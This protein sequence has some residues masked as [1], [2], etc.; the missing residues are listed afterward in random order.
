ML[1]NVMGTLFIGSDEDVSEFME[2][3]PDG[4]IIHAAKEPWHRK[5]VGYKGRACPKDSPYYL[6]HETKDELT[7]NL[8]DAPDPKYISKRC[9]DKAEECIR[10]NWALRRPVLVHCNQGR[11][12]SCGVV[13][14]CLMSVRYILRS[15]REGGPLPAGT[16]DKEIAILTYLYPD[17]KLGAG[18]EGALREW[19]EEGK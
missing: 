5:A 7:L 13:L 18:V 16:L 9:F 4:F 6:Y 8:V 1:V 12:R 11:S 19:W 17:L 14:H 2:D 10:A 15:P 3:Y